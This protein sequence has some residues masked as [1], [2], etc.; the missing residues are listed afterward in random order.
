MKKNSGDPMIEFRQFKVS[1][2]KECVDLFIRVF[3]ANPW[4]D[5][6]NM[7]SA[8]EYLWEFIISPSFIGFIAVII[9]KIVGV[10]F[11]HKRS[12]WQGKEFEIDEM[13]VDAE[14][15]GKGIGTRLFEFMTENL[16]EQGIRNYVLMTG[17]DLP[18]ESFY[19]KNGFYRND[20]IV[21]L[22]YKGN[23]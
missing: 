18:A 10:C 23:F 11:G 22:N 12:Y 9:E 16:K 4:N 1:D 8:T 17:K 7:D 2:T 13:Y 14:M 6:W 3:N 15:Q 5:R 19:R 20:Y 21:L